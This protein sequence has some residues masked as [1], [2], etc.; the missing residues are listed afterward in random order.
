MS[1]RAVRPVALRRPKEPPEDS[2]RLRVIVGALVMLAVI[3]V[4]AQGALDAATAAGALVAV[5]AGYAFS[6]ARRGRPSLVVKLFLAAGLVL[7][8]GAFLQRVRFAQT[9]DE[10]RAPLASLFIWVQALHAFDV[11]RRRD[12]SFSVVSSVILMAEAA[13]LSL[14][15]A[16]LLLLVPWVVLAAAWL[17][18]TQRPVRPDVREPRFVRRITPAS[19][20]RTFAAARAASAGATAVAVGVAAVFLAMP[21]LPGTYVRLPPFA[22]RHAVPVPSFDGSVANPSLPSAG[23]NGVVDFAAVA[24]PGFGSSVDLR[25]RGR[26]SDRLV[27]LVRSPQPALWRGQVYDT[28][29]GTRWTESDSR[30]TTIGQTAGSGFEVPPTPEPSAASGSPAPIAGAPVESRRV[31]TTFYVR[32]PQP[33]IVFAAFAPQRV[34]FP[35]AQLSIGPGTSLRAPILLDRGL[36]YSVISAIPVTTP[37]TLRADA[38][39]IDPRTVRPYTQLPA[40]LPRRDLAL[41][42]RITAGART[43]YDRVLAV[44]R[45]LRTHTRYDLDVPRDPP[46]VDAVDEFLFERR[47]GFCEHIASA[48]AVLLRAVGVPTRFV[49]GFGPGERNPL[50]GYLEVREAD[51]HAWIEVLYPGLGWVPYDPTFGV[52]AADPG[53]AWFVAP[54]LLRAVGRWAS[55]AIPAPVRASVRAA[56]RGVAVLA[57]RAAAAWPL[58]AAS[59]ALTA[60]VALGAGRRR[61]RRRLP[62]LTGAAAAFDRMTTALASRGSPREPQQ[63]PAEY[64]ER[65]RRS[66]L[67][68]AAL[69][70]AERVVRLFELERFGQ[71][72]PAADDVADALA[73][74]ERIARGLR[75]RPGPARPSARPFADV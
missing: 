48:M 13:S 4:I 44:Q 53:A 1:V 22:L 31:V 8:L 19:R 35:A 26:L 67:D 3:S 61:R 2:L 20:H 43:E 23:G 55:H 29:D 42:R 66:D 14:D 74:A 45:W 5:P 12:L 37:A 52:P 24:Y 9:V 15:T 68:A 72:P 28:F 32:E 47:R 46:G 73:A 27:M 6:Y 65:L 16:Y 21:R 56:G 71:D 38:G 11:P 7:A 30:T 49:T 63:T 70:D 34:F 17:Y 59:L 40:D 58:A 50:T 33:N 41:A 57:R 69:K 18:A 54:G 25:A 64:L 10:A 62:P 60:L 36:V 51:A 75:P 39:R